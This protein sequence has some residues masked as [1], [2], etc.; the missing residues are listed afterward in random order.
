MTRCHPQA[1]QRHS[2]E[3]GLANRQTRVPCDEG[4]H[5]RPPSR[6]NPRNESV[7]AASEMPVRQ[8]V[9]GP[10]SSVELVPGSTAVAASA[11][12]HGWCSHGVHRSGGQ[13]TRRPAEP[14][15]HSL[16][17]A[18]RSQRSS[19]ECAGRGSGDGQGARRRASWRMVGSFSD[20]C[21]QRANSHMW[22]RCG[23]RSSSPAIRF[24]RPEG[25]A[26]SR[27]SQF[28]MC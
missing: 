23:S 9:Q 10:V 26:M 19:H 3:A 6:S 8:R 25:S 21:A 27:A 24:A 12:D 14:Q 22:T 4:R 2:R 28:S 17:G 16:S 7:G 13:A 5:P 20:S 11:L 18:L 15:Q 1:G